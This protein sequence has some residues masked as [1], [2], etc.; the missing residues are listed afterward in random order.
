MRLRKVEETKDGIKRVYYI[1]EQ[2]LLQGEYLSY[3]QGTKI[4]LKRYNYKDGKL[5]GDCFKY[6]ACGM[7]WIHLVYDNGVKVEDKTKPGI[8]KEESG[9]YKGRKVYKVEEVD[10]YGFYSIYYVDNYNMICGVFREFYPNGDLYMVGN[11]EDGK[12]H[13]KLTTYIGDTPTV[14]IYEKGEFIKEVKQ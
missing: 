3:Y 6:C 13:G 12:P 11:F 1:D 8:H 9:R 2:G 4:L 14:E 10:E 7:V 5:H